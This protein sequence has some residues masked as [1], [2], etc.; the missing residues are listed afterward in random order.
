MSLGGSDCADQAWVVF[1]SSEGKFYQ[2][3][4]EG[5]VSALWPFIEARKIQLFCVDSVDSESFFCGWKN[6]EGKAARHVEYDRYVRDE[7]G[8]R[9]AT[10]WSFIDPRL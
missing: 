5:M 9:F 8:S 4:D 1:P 3:E 10:Y 7:V 6:A 2:F